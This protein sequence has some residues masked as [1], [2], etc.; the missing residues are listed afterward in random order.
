MKGLVAMILAL[1]VALTGV[2]IVNG[3]VIAAEEG[4]NKVVVKKEQSQIP[5]CC[6]SAMENGNMMHKL[7]SEQLGG[8]TLDFPGD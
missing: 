3:P 5:E 2:M 8:D 6:R 7:S 4:S 1:M